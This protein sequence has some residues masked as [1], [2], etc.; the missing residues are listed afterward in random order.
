MC[1]RLTQ[2]SGDLLLVP[3]LEV[4]RPLLASLL[5]SPAAMKK[6]PT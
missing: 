4:S 1:Y 5:S 2:F 3:V 6:N